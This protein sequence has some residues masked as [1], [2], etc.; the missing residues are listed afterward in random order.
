MT[1]APNINEGKPWS[2]MDLK[3]LHDYAATGASVEWL[4]DYLCRTEDEVRAQ[5]RLEGLHPWPPHSGN[6]G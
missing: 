6:Q 4:A 3:D 1:D 5:M 2:A